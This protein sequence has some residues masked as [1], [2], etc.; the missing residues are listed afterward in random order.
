MED[1]LPRLCVVAL[2]SLYKPRTRGQIL[3]F[4]PDADARFLWYFYLA[5]V[6]CGVSWPCTT[7]L[8]NAVFFID[9]PFPV[10]TP[11]SDAGPSYLRGFS[12]ER[13]RSGR[14]DDISRVVAFARGT[15][16]PRGGGGKNHY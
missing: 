5:S 7:T 8:R 9:L 12:I 3:P 1:L 13:T 14:R 2:N 10:P 16:A 6:A 4:F 11:V 15:Y